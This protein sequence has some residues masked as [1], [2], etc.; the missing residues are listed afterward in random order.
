ME[1][2]T[3]APYPYVS[4]VKEGFE[5]SKRFTARVNEA[6]RRADNIAT[7]K[8]LERRV[9]DWKNHHIGNFG[10]L[11]A[12]GS[13]NAST[14]KKVKKSDSILKK[15]GSV[16]SP[17]VPLSAQAKKS[18][19]PLMLKGRIFLSNVTLAKS[20][21]IDG[22]FQF[23]SCY[24]L[25][26][27]CCSGVNGLEVWWRGDD[28]L[29][30]FTLKCRTEEQ[31][32]M[33]GKELN[34]LIEEAHRR[35]HIVEPA[36]SPTFGLSVALPSMMV[37]A[38]SSMN[39][40][41]PISTTSSSVSLGRGRS[42]RQNGGNSQIPLPVQNS[43]QRLYYD[44]DASVEDNYDDSVAD[45]RDRTSLYMRRQGSTT[46]RSHTSSSS[47][48]GHSSGTRPL[49]DGYPGHHYQHSSSNFR[50]QPPMPNQ[51]HQPARP[52]LKS[53]FSSLKLGSEYAEDEEPRVR[54]VNS[55]QHVPE[56]SASSPFGNPRLRSASTSQQAH[57]QQQHPKVPNGKSKAWSA[58]TS[59][60]SLMSNWVDVKRDSGSS[61]QSDQSSGYSTND[62]SGESPI[63]P[64][65]SSGSNIST[66]VLMKSKQSEAY[67]HRLMSP[68]PPNVS[69]GNVN[70]TNV[71]EEK[72]KIKVHYRQDIFVIMVVKSINYQ[73]LVLR[74][75]QKVR[76]CGGE[77]DNSPLR[78]KYMDEENDMITLGSDEDIQMAFDTN[79][80]Q[81]SFHVA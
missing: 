63:T 4:D 11:P 1:S 38:G 74:V 41:Q 25:M 70:A 61:G 10:A 28:E 30:F 24:Y 13:N 40:H 37:A 7:V 62:Q 80:P 54:A 3:G 22:G 20:V 26:L 67:Q 64:Y 68:P 51:H 76:L 35:S 57:Q 46:T 31:M 2:S 27:I 23:L 55:A 18:T 33:W 59:Q 69:A 39:S 43:Q 60:S 17:P 29:E 73:D 6:Q 9:I 66:S 48:G 52:V 36:R 50:N 56:R 21:M 44:D 53:Q 12:P 81:I 72:V 8:A 78:I 71:N 15:G 42:F 65:G 14:L 5:A 77:R 47:Y 58:A 19:G 32:K 45:E 49:M 79:L 75:A 16:S 34:I